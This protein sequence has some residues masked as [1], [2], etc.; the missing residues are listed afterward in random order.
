MPP[1]TSQAMIRAIAPLAL[2]VVAAASASAQST[3]AARPPIIDVHWHAALAPSDLKTPQAIAG[4]RTTMAALDSLNVRY[5]VVNGVPDALAVWRDEY[6]DRVIPGLLFPCEN[7][8]A[9][10]NGRPCFPG[11]AVFPDTV[12]LRGELKAGRVRMLGE[13]TAE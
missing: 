7:G 6:P 11:G 10:N 12:W 1:Q 5:L 2:A 3:G 9:P 4:R 8:L 13:I